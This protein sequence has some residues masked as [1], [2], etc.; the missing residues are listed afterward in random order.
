MTTSAS[1]QAYSSHS[2]QVYFDELQALYDVY[3]P[4]VAPFLR[5]ITTETLI[6]LVGDAEEQTYY[7]HGL[8]VLSWPSG[9][10]ECPPVSYLAS[11]PVSFPLIGLTQLTQYLIICHTS[12]LSSG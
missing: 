6:P 1:K 9:M 12:N 10:F 8:D 2:T 11:I 3:R 7:I 5:S 4:Y